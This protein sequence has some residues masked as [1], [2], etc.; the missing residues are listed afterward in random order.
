M[1]C[2]GKERIA[3]IELARFCCMRIFNDSRCLGGNKFMKIQGRTQPRENIVPFVQL[4]SFERAF[5]LKDYRIA[6]IKALRN[7]EVEEELYIIY[8]S[9]YSFL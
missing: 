3:W 1:D 2:M 6:A 5:E 8:G 7:T 9:E 4:P